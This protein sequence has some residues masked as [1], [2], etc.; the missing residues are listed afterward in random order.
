MAASPLAKQLHLHV[1]VHLNF[2]WSCSCWLKV[3][4]PTELKVLSEDESHRL[5]LLIVARV[6]YSYCRKLRNRLP[7]DL[8]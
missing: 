6:E 8:R 3:K 1:K 7:N 5:V 4:A 2:Y